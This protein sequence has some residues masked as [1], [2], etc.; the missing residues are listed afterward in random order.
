MK[1]AL[2]STFVN[3]L[4]V[5]RTWIERHRQLGISQ[6]YLF[7]DDPAEALRYAALELPDVRWFARGPE[8][9]ARWQQQTSWPEYA[10]FVDSEWYA[11]QCLNVDIGFAQAKADGCDWLI[12]IDIDEE[13]YAPGPRTLAECLAAHAGDDVLYL[14]NHEGI[15][16][17]WHVE[18]YLLEVSLFKKHPDMLTATQLLQIGR[19][20]GMRYYLAY[21]NGKAAV[22]LHGSAVRGEGVHW[23]QP[24]NKKGQATELCVLHYANCG[25][26]WFFEKFRTIGHFSD[27]WFGNIEIKPVMPFM[28]ESR[29]AV[30][31][32][33]IHDA[34]RLYEQRVM[35]QGGL[36]ASRDELLDAGIL[37]R[38]PR[39]AFTLL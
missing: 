10:A 11:R 30:A 17:T 33:S 27:T 15:P 14:N 19:H 36:P 29:T 39:T 34:T 5:L 20:F 13:V 21:S 32:G 2:V 23:F 1:I 31:G 7:A 37:M 3:A 16:E 9:A 8:L 28:I 35:R 26:N 22:N 6:F 38:I 18:D 4:P 12:H 24:C 25:F